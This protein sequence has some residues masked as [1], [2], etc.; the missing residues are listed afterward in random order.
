MFLYLVY[1]KFWKY[2]NI[3]GDLPTWYHWHN[4]DEDLDMDNGDQ[5]DYC[6]SL[7][8]RILFRKL[9]SFSFSYHSSWGASFGYS[10]HCLECRTLQELIEE[11]YFFCLMM[12]YCSSQ[13]SCKP[14]SVELDASHLITVR[15]IYLC[16]QIKRGYFCLR[17]RPVSPNVV[18]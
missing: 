15:V 7:R 17:S 12:F 16:F 4:V 18:C 1:K 3:D 5:G 2:Q 14:L 8:R 10:Y 11:S 13:K 9:D 6:S